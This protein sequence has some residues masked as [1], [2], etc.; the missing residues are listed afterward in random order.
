M[1]TK[2][3]LR[4][5][6]IVQNIKLGCNHICHFV[7]DSLFAQF[8]RKWNYNVLK[9]W[10]KLEQIDNELAKTNAI[11]SIRVYHDWL[12]LDFR[13]QPEHLD[14]YISQTY[15]G[16]RFR[17]IKPHSS[18]HKLTN[19]ERQ[20]N[21]WISSRASFVDDPG[22]VSNNALFVFLFTLLSLCTLEKIKKRTNQ[23]NTVPNPGARWITGSAQRTKESS[24]S[25]STDETMNDSKQTGWSSGGSFI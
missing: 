10:C 14:H 7:F 1:S 15:S 21:R 22:F 11:C 19:L 9:K 16:R 3:A 6:P 2:L 5:T 24:S 8:W 25:S 13:V 20:F 17:W 4:V 18:V 23:M 12:T